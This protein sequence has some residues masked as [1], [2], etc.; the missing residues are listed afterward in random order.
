MPFEFLSTEMQ[1]MSRAEKF[2]DRMARPPVKEIGRGTIK[3]VEKIKKHLTKSDRVLDFGC[4]NGTI[5]FQFAGH[6]QQVEAIDISAKNIALAKKE[7]TGRGIQ[8]IHFAQAVLFDEHYKEES[9]DVVLAFYILHLLEDRE[10]VIQRINKLLKP[11]GIFIS[12]S[13]CLGEKK[14]F[15]TVALSLLSKTGIVPHL[16]FIKG[17]ELENLMVKENFQIIET[18]ILDQSPLDYFIAAKKV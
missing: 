18:K 16:N 8:N 12:A 9:F 7:A 17:I 4:G 10:Q 5:S 15:L 14:S 6:V 1:R 13:A 2:W 3:T 11:G